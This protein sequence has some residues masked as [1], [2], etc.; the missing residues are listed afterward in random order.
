MNETTKCV[1]HAPCEE[2]LELRF[3]SFNWNPK[4]GPIRPVCQRCFDRVMQER[5]ESDGEV[6][7]WEIL[8]LVT[9][10]K[11]VVLECWGAVDERGAG[12][13]IV[14]FFGE[15][16]EGMNNGHW[17]GSMTGWV[18][19]LEICKVVPAGEKRRLRITIEVLED[20]TNG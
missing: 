11:R 14:A 1:L 18:Y 17:Q 12:D 20:T 19:S 5:A 13:G 8:P 10:S 3:L 16:P 15:A 6:V 2:G 9:S 7:S 4:G